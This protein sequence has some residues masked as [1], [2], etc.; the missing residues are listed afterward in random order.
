MLDKIPAGGTAKVAIM[1][2]G[3]QKD[4]VMTPRF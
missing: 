3:V 2:K 1:R 4:L